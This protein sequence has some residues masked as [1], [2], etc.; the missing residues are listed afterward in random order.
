MPSKTPHCKGNESQDTVSL[1]ETVLMST[2]RGTRFPKAN[3]FVKY[4]SWG[5]EVEEVHGWSQYVGR[6]NTTLGWGYMRSIS[7]PNRGTR[8][9][10]R[11]TTRQGISCVEGGTKW[12]NSEGRAKWPVGYSEYVDDVG[13]GR[14]WIMLQ[15]RVTWVAF[16]QKERSKSP[17]VMTKRYVNA[18]NKGFLQVPN[19]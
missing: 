10:V 4:T 5:E 19:K 11:G 14:W 18:G 3:G 13:K 12:R 7:G 6:L 8:S 17:K 16:G 9:S 2:K 1:M 15:P